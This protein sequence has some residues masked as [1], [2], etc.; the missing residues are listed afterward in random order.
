MA[1]VVWVVLEYDTGSDES[2]VVAVVDSEEKAK[3]EEAKGMKHRPRDY[4]E[5]D[6]K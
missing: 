3:A 2:H 5:W 4:Q 1:G 6:V